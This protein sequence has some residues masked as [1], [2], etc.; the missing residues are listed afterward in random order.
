MFGYVR[1]HKPSLTCGDYER[2]RAVYCSLCGALGRRYGIAAR[3][4]LRYD[5]TFLA[6]VA[7]AEQADCPRFRR[8]S[9]TFCP[10]KRCGRCGE[11]KNRA[12]AWTADASMAMLCC[13]WR[14]AW[15]DAPW[16]AKPLPALAA[17]LFLFWARR[18][19]RSA[20]AAWRA[21]ASAVRAQRLVEC[22]TAPAVDACAHPSAHALG[23]L[24]A[25]CNKEN[26]ARAQLLYRLGYLLGRWV[27]F[28]DAADD[29]ERDRRRGSFNPFVAAQDSQ[30][31][32]IL[33]ATAAD[34]W[35][36]WEALAP[37]RFAP[38]FENILTQG[39][40]ATEE[41]IFS[42]KSKKQRRRTV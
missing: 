8:A 1:P 14:D 30:P 13:K 11:K 35:E 15:D 32:E 17:P 4:G 36:A 39:L 18:A 7:L 12:L 40:A 9:C 42:A 24:L 10:W 20:P 6:L 29:L 38:I 21:T 33:S 26:P 27:Y 23:L 19:K 3:L 2:Y 37:I 34:L 16:Y 28:A 22:E 31:R 41:R 25:Q 5:M